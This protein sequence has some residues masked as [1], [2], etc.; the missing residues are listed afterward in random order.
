MM[1]EASI[2]RAFVREMKTAG[3]TT[4]KL[5]LAHDVAW[6]DRLVLLPG[7][8]VAWVE[9]KAPGKKAR[10]L[11]AHRQKMLRELGH[12]VI[13]TDKLATAILFVRSQFSAALKGW[14]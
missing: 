13:T 7:G 6:P 11:Q 5:Q 12:S 3:I 14:M 2:E 8:R 10:A 9:L 1:R 4:I